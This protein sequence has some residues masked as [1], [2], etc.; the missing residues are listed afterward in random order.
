MS[1][2][3]P[4]RGALFVARGITAPEEPPEEPGI[5]ASSAAGAFGVWEERLQMN[6]LHRAFTMYETDI[7]SP[8][9]LTSEPN[10]LR[11]F[12]VVDPAHIDTVLFRDATE[13]AI[14]F[15]IIPDTEV[16]NWFCNFAE[17]PNSSSICHAPDGQIWLMMEIKW[18]DALHDTFFHSRSISFSPV[19]FTV[20]SVASPAVLTIA[21]APTNNEDYLTEGLPI[22]I[23]GGTVHMADF[24]TDPSGTLPTGLEKGGQVYYVRNPTGGG[25]SIGDTCNLSLTPSGALIDTTG[26]SQSGNHYYTHQAAQGGIKFFDIVGGDYPG[27]PGATYGQDPYNNWTHWFSS[28]T[29][30][31]VIQTYNQFRWPQ[32]YGRDYNQSDAG[33][34]ERASPT[35]D[36][37][38]QNDY[39]GGGVCLLETLPAQGEGP[40]IPG[41]GGCWEFPKNRWVPMMLGITFLGDRF[42]NPTNNVWTADARREVFINDTDGGPWVRIINFGPE[43]E[44]YFGQCVHDWFDSAFG[45]LVDTDVGLGKSYVFPYMTN[46]APEQLHDVGKVWVRRLIAASERIAAPMTLAPNAPAAGNWREISGGNTMRDI[47]GPDV[48]TGQDILSVL[49]V[50]NSA[51]YI[52]DAGPYGLY[53][54][55]GGGHC[56]NVDQAYGQHL[57]G[58]D[59]DCL[60]KSLNPLTVTDQTIPSGLITFNDGGGAFPD[61]D[62][63][64]ASGYSEPAPAHTY[65]TK[66]AIP[67]S[68]F[69]NENG[70][71]CIAVLNSVGCGGGGSHVAISLASPA[72]F[73]VQPG[74][75]LLAEGDSFWLGYAGDLPT[76]LVTGTEYFARNVS[77]TT[78]NASAT[79]LGALI[80]T[81]VYNGGTYVAYRQPFEGPNVP[82]TRSYAWFQDMDLALDADVEVRK[83]SWSRSTNAVPANCG[84]GNGNSAVYDPVRQCVWYYGGGAPT[85]FGKLD[86][87]T[88]T[89][90]SVAHNEPALNSDG[91]L[92]GG[93]CPTLDCIVWY[94]FNANTPGNQKLYVWKPNEA[95]D[96]GVL[97][98][99]GVGSMTG[100]PPVSLVGLE[101]VPHAAIQEFYGMQYTTVRNVIIDTTTDVITATGHAIPENQKL[102]MD[103]VGGVQPSPLG[104]NT[105]YAKNVTTDTLQISLTPGGAALDMSGAQSGEQYIR[106]AYPRA[107]MIRL[108]PPASLPGTWEWDFED[109]IAE[110]GATLVANDSVNPRY[111]ALRWAW[112]YMSLIWGN[113][114]E[115]KT[116][117]FRPLRATSI[118]EE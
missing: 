1:R 39:N 105:Y 5:P 22:W 52:R 101:W 63:E 41:P 83:T 9:P 29:T 77:G 80:D 40:T 2:L 6:G 54:Q 61:G 71:M 81:S 53:H 55:W 19:R 66:V 82:T 65:D 58:V 95:G 4:G 99:I 64:L 90:T 97:H 35:F 46:K 50:W 17:N 31:T 85:H 115:G 110:G 15:D 86:V 28:A 75:P 34:E 42:Q 13:K 32:A 38:R 27:G 100:T 62:V 73:T 37:D 7:L 51:V 118:D 14:R 116:N 16:A 84:G 108:I 3:I 45:S 111:N 21:V 59:A 25:D 20:A 43:T 107:R 11:N 98:I 106:A 104:G 12:G 79:A 70:A 48:L 26:G 114:T 56:L 94:W 10:Y 36:H 112:P 8:A 68:V 67:A 24:S 44:G 72:V 117:L 103:N 30:K 113:S 87:A 57:A 78:F 96:D 109:F 60:W 76:G 47:H 69:G 33:F 18:N 92:T 102:W 23:C 74:H 89:W 93:Y 91:D 88:R 49:N